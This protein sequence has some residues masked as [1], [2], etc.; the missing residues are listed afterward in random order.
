MQYQRKLYETFWRGV[1]WIFPPECLGCGKEGSVICEACLQK[2]QF[3]DRNRC[4]FC[5]RT[6][7]KEGIC[8]RC[9]HED[10]FFTEIRCL[11]NYEGITQ[12]AV[13]RLK[14]ENDL[15]VAFV[16]AELLTNLVQSANWMIEL[17]IP[18]PLSQKRLDERGYNQAAL[19]ARPL[20]LNLGRPFTPKGL[21]RIRE[22]RSQVN[23]N[24]RQR[25]ENVQ[26]AFIADPLIVRDRSIL[27]VDDV[28]TTGATMNAAAEALNQ[29]GCLRVFALTVAKAVQRNSNID[30]LLLDNV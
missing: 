29:A 2:I 4:I 5:G 6:M 14:Y 12:E 23:L 25:K 20:S 7:T 27:L 28:Y 8:Q 11:A 16:L 17:V 3:L 21:A 15:A 24:I 22:T 1:D 30:N 10:H 26:N 13:R 19:L 18:V 9:R